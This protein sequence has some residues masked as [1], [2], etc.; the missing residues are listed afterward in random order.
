MKSV[1]YA[2]VA[3]SA[4]AGCTADRPS[5]AASL[6]HTATASSRARVAEPSGYASAAVGDNS[7]EVTYAGPWGGSR[8]AIEGALLY[9][10]ALLTRQHEKTWFRFLHMPG[11]AGPLSHPARLSPS[12]GSAYGHWQP[13]WSYQTAS[14]WQPWHPEW[15]APFWADTADGRGV[16]QVEAHAMIELGRGPSTAAEQ[17]DFDVAAVLRDLRPAFG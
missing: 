4:L 12:F 17:T 7:Y 1:I 3:L 6:P 8:D 9:R 13:L 5:D 16:R 10:A 14:G 11:E 15:A 2:I